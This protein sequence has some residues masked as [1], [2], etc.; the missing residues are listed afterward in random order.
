[1]NG[2]EANKRLVELT[3]HEEHGEFYEDAGEFLPLNVWANRGFNPEA[4][5]DKTL[6][7]DR[8]THPV[9]GET[10]RVS[11]LRGGHRG[12]KS[13]GKTDTLKAAGSPGSSGGPSPLALVAPDPQL[14][15]GDKEDSSSSSSSSSRHKKSKKSKKDK[16]DKKKARKA[17]KKLNLKR[18]RSADKASLSSTCVWGSIIIKRPCRWVSLYCVRHC[19]INYTARLSLHLVSPLS[20]FVAEIG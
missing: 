12:S 4:I 3:V 14:A 13:V 17:Q 11:V 2:A 10:F 5:R 20:D 7:K 9:L 16:K 6:P 15:L 19:R 8:R 1:M 18:P